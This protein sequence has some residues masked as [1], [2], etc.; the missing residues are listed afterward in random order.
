M[1]VIE[2][3]L[4]SPAYYK[5]ARPRFLRGGIA[6]EDRVSYVKQHNIVFHMLKS[7]LGRIF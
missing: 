1:Y 5:M 7:Y 6:L 3:D 4:K 2:E